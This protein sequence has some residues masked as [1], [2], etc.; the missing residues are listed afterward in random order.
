MALPFGLREPDSPSNAPP[1]QSWMSDGLPPSPPAAQRRALSALSVAAPLL[2]EVLPLEAWLITLPVAQGL[3]PTDAALPFWYLL[4]TG[5]V[6]WLVGH[7]CR[8]RTR[9]TVLAASAGPF[10]VL[11]VILLRI[12]PS[13]SHRTPLSGIGAGLIVVV[14][15]LWWRG[16]RHGTGTLTSTQVMHQMTWGLAATVFAGII[17]LPAPPER[18]QMIEGLLT[19]LL[20]VQVFCVLL[21][22][23]QARIATQQARPGADPIF[24]AARV[25]QVSYA[26]VVAGVLVLSASV[27]N[28]EVNPGLVRTL[29]TAAGLDGPLNVLDLLLQR[30]VAVLIGWFA[31]PSARPQP[32]VRQVGTPPSQP[33]CVAHPDFPDCTVH[34]NH[35]PSA[36]PFQVL[37]LVGTALLL[38]GALAV[39]LARRHI[40]QTQRRSDQENGEVRESLDSRALL[41]AQL[42]ALF[43]PRRGAGR[44]R[45]DLPPGSMRA[46][47]RDLLRATAGRGFARRA[48]ETP[49]E[50]AQR[51]RQFVPPVTSDISAHDD[52]EAVSEAY[53]R[54]RYGGYE[55]PKVEMSDLRAS[56]HRLITLIH[57]RTMRSGSRR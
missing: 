22:L 38:L 4:T 25:R 48:S 55:I 2:A 35:P 1:V 52:V 23:T 49:A 9:V 46:L 42:R 41:G 39:Y 51:L 6:A 53:A 31:Q 5:L 24:L 21:V 27:V 11:T 10:A 13:M 8:D 29:L 45:D 7:L 17:A 44:H 43:S 56:A 3:S 37:F 26:T 18:R 15:F 30:L 12:S 33:W 57:R 47:Y 19:L 34:F 32:P 40:W 28:L 36:P 14:V 54:V 20:P 50:Y 16:L